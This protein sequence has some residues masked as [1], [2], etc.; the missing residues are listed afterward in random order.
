M[1][2]TGTPATSGTPF[3]QTLH[4]VA[5][6]VLDAVFHRGWMA[7]LCYHTGMQGHVALDE[8]T[9][10]LPRAPGAPPLRVAFA[11]DFHAG[12]IT[13]PAQL[14]H[15]CRLLS[16][17]RPA[18]LLLGGDFVS[19]NVGYVDALSDRLAAVRAPLGK[20]AVL[21]N[22]DYRRRRSRL[23]T[24]ALERAGVEL[25]TNRNVRL[26]APHD[27]LWICGLD[28]PLRGTPDRDP[29]FRGADGTRIVLMHAP[30]DLLE[31]GDERFDLA[32]CGHTH[33]G[34]VALPWGRPLLLPDGQLNARFPHGWFRLGDAQ[35]LVSRG[36]GCSGIP[37]RVFAWP[38]VHLL[39]V[40]GR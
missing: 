14:D 5:D 34:Q 15:A 26:P 25:L 40:E 38:Q 30:D 2:A 4:E 33:G 39:A 24:R 23:V 12:P 6:R 18:L 32:L 28:D 35:L 9:V 20:Y 10:R 22:H 29:A 7:S 16:D 17:A 1:S 36:I 21:G 3:R 13:Y 31:I 19:L 27:D 8:R 37:V 11:S